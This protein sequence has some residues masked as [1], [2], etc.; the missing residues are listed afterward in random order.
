MEVSP[1]VEVT[2]GMGRNGSEWVL[3]G[4]VGG[5]G[6]LQAW[7]AGSESGFMSRLGR[8]GRNGSEWV[9]EGRVGVRIH[10]LHPDLKP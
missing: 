4:R 2:V 9:L 8:Q 1:T 10:V 7:K 6:H 3:E 5:Q